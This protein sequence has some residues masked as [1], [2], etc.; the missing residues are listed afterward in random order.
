MSYT[1]T[2]WTTGD[3][4]TA[5]ALNKIEQ[6]IADGGGGGVDAVIYF[7]NSTVGYQVYGD[8]NKALEKAQQGIPLTAY[9]LGYYQSTSSG[10]S[11][12]GYN[13]LGTYYS[14]NY[15]NQID[16]LITAGVGYRWTASGVERF[17]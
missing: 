15:P 10:F 5:S 13:F 1:P 9:E 11:A 2:T 14:S 17:D 12:G 3:T 8:F 7:P 4:I 16:L 6:G